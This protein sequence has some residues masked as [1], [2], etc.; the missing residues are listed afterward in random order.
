M[1]GQTHRTGAGLEGDES[2]GPCQQE[3]D[4]AGDQTNPR[5]GDSRHRGLTGRENVVTRHARGREEPPQDAGDVG[6]RGSGQVEDEDESCHGQQHPEEGEAVRR[7]PSA[8]PDPEDDEDRAEVFEEQ[9]HADVEGLHRPEVA[10]LCGR[11]AE[12]AIEPDE[13]EMGPQFGPAAAH[14]DQRPR[15]QD[16]RGAGDADRDDGS[17]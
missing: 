14:E 8:A 1:T 2:D 12:E 15:Q 10:E 17:G 9:G 16:E 3:K 7:A 5:E 4:R 13:R 6:W 11:D